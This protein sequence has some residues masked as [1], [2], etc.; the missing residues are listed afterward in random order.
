[1]DYVLQTHE[2]TK[3]FGKKAAVDKVSMN[4]A[5][6][7]IYGFIGKNGAGKTTTMKMVLGMLFPTGGT[8]KLFGKN[9]ISGASS[10][11]EALRQAKIFTIAAQKVEV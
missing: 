2:L 5:K 9:I 3:I 4:I 11:E 10:Y 8:M 7:D 6:G 1:M